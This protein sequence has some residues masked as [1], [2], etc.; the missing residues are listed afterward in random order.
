MLRRKSRTI[1]MLEGNPAY[2][3]MMFSV[4]LIFGNI[5]Q[6][7]YYITDAVI[8]GN[9]ISIQALAAVNSCSWITWLLNA[10]ARD[11]SNTLSI[12]AS[13]SVGEGDQ[14]RVKKIVGNACTITL[15]LSVFLTVLAECHLDEIFQLFKVQSDILQMTREY[16]SVV[17]IGIPFVLIYNVAAALLRAAGNSSITFYAVSV[18]TVINITLDLLF[19]VGF[20]W[21]VRGGALATVI[22]QF[23]AMLIA[24][25]PL[26]K[27]SMFTTKLEDW[28]LEGK[29][30]GQVVSLWTP[31]FV[32]SAVISIGGSFVSRNVNAIG[33]YFTA[34]ISSATKIFTL[35]ESLIMAIQTGLSV[36]IGQNLGAGQTKRVRTGV[37]QIVLLAL[38]LSVVLNIIVQSLAPHLVNMFLSQADP[39]YE[40]TLHVAVQYVRVITLGMF[41]MAP[42]YLYR[43]AIQTLGHPRYPMYAGF[44]QLAA[45]VFSVSVLPA[46]IGVYGYYL[47]TILAWAVTL[48]VVTIPYYKYIRQLLENSGDC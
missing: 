21:G 22:A 8:V 24:V 2:L 34:G 31:M 46:F 39:L 29:L 41:I 26:V 10:I 4:P 15:I 32:N 44:L 16:F 11:L 19:I 35:L 6:Q 43:I 36:F 20:G 12:L 3:V 23:A 37:H 17:L 7:M 33:P 1:H 13:Y 25:I 45:R 42:M 9:F 47:A 5:L 30:M 14:A 48:P 40:E 27:S 18:S 28:K 38:G